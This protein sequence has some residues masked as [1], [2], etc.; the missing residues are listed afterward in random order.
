MTE[1][2]TNFTERGKGKIVTLY[3]PAGTKAEQIGEILLIL[4]DGKL[5]M[6][7]SYLWRDKIVEFEWDPGLNETAV[8]RELNRLKQEFPGLRIEFGE[9]SA[10][11]I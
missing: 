4:F 1:A 8:D 6:P 10:I 11:T 2:Q 9:S 7:I 3:F 5:G